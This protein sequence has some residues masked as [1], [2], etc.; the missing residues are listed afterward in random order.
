MST[1]SMLSDYSDGLASMSGLRDSRDSLSMSAFRDPYSSMMAPS[2]STSIAASPA[3]YLHPVSSAGGRPS[4]AGG[5]SR[6]PSSASN[7]SLSD[8]DTSGTMTTTGAAGANHGRTS[9]LTMSVMRDR[10]RHDAS[11]LHNAS[12][13]SDAYSDTYSQSDYSDIRSDAEVGASTP[14]G[15][16]SKALSTSSSFSDLSSLSRSSSRLSQSSLQ[17]SQSDASK[18]FKVVIRVRPPLPRELNPMNGMKKFVNIVEVTEDSRGIVLSEN[19]GSG[20]D[21]G[22]I[23]TKHAF[24]FDQVQRSAHSVAFVGSI[25]VLHFHSFIN[26]SFVSI[27]VHASPHQV[28]GE[29]RGQ[30]DVYEQTARDAV[31]STL[32][33]YNA[34]IIAYALQTPST[35]FLLYFS[36]VSTNSGVHSFWLAPLA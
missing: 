10:D 23:Y 26:L 17:S 16:G 36:W 28:Y 15:L 27:H 7:M 5:H 30:R 6:Y 4:S 21:G 2:P 35:L 12:Y 18:N 9:G 11:L 33:G 8:I 22:G 34:T 32:Q 24:T 31:L 25:H 13:A 20:D 14:S 3:S 29:H 19:A 1:D